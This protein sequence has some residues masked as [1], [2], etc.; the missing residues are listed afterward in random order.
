MKG[1]GILV[2]LLGTHFFLFPH[3]ICAAFTCRSDRCHFPNFLLSFIRLVPPTLTASISPRLAA[4]STTCCDVSLRWA[5]SVVDRRSIPTLYM[6]S[7]AFIVGE[8]EAQLCQLLRVYLR[9]VW[10][11]V[12]CIEVD[13]NPSAAID[14]SLVLFRQLLFHQNLLLK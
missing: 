10:L 7:Y 12:M 2:I 9:E 4:R 13:D 11:G 3:R 6:N 5:A 8:G 1:N 14:R